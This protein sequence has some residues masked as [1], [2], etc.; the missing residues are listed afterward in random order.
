MLKFLLANKQKVSKKAFN[1]VRS[2]QSERWMITMGAANSYLPLVHSILTGQYK[3]YHDDSEDREREE[4]EDENTV[5]YAVSSSE[6]YGLHSARSLASNSVSNN[7]PLIAI[8]PY[9]AAVQKYGGWCALGTE[10]LAERI[11][12][13]ADN[14]RVSAIILD[15]DSPG[16]SADA[17][18][19]PSAA[20]NYAKEKKP[21]IGYAGNGM[22]ASAAYWIMSH[23][24]EIYATYET[25]E[26]GSIGTYITLVN[27]E[28]FLASYYNS[29]VHQVYA[30]KSTE[31]NKGYRDITAE[32]SSE[33]WLLEK[34][35]DPFNDI[36]I[37]TVKNN[38]PSINEDVFKGRLYMANDA[39][40]MG[41]IDGMK[42]FEEVLNRASE[43]SENFNSKNTMWGKNKKAKALVDADASDINDEMV[44]EA[45]AE[46]ASKGLVFISSTDLSE[47]REAAAKAS[48]AKGETPAIDGAVASALGLSVS[49]KG[50]TNEAGQATTLEAAATALTARVAELEAENK[51]LREASA[52]I[53]ITDTTKEKETAESNQSNPE[54]EGM[55]AGIEE[56]LNNY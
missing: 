6:D 37:K 31:K 14:P 18:S 17:V 39:L 27:Y 41:L 25:D 48:E 24:D 12:Y 7:Q 26:I 13:E 9:K 49:E 33:K 35:L 19:H 50:L 29:D 44:Q 43:L 16:G 10:E 53:V 45:N 34:E 11:R 3:N 21:V 1:F 28:K 38:R 40:E 4:V 36:F 15:M 30:S 22:T 54:I 52:G 46:I 55:Y 56:K 47:L 5:R 32:K 20:I 2:I 23:C 51:T 42:S 8:I